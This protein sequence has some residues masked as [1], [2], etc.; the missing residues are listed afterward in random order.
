M[1]YSRAKKVIEATYTDR[2]TVTEHRKSID[3]ETKLAAW[4]DCPKT[5]YNM[6]E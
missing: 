6:T 3:K 5:R 4:A 1:N 2:C